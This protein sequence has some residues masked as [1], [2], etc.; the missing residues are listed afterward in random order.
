MSPH[1]A[2][3]EIWLS[4]HKVRVRI[5]S[6]GCPTQ[7]F[8]DQAAHFFYLLLPIR[9]RCNLTPPLFQSG[10]IEL[11]SIAFRWIARSQVPTELKLKEHDT[12]R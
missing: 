6:S 9:L 3:L 10:I 11:R 2:V 4:P 1:L 12:S 8:F 5:H 7:M